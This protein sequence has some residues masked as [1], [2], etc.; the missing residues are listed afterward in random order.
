MTEYFASKK[1]YCTRYFSLSMFYIFI[2]IPIFSKKPFTIAFMSAPSQLQMTELTRQRNHSK[3]YMCVQ[4]HIH[5]IKSW[6]NYLFF[7]VVKRCR[8]TSYQNV[9]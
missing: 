5:L 9:S 2:F 3:L 1:D 6:C 7:C 8:P 4:I